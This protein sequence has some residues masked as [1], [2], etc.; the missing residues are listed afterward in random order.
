MTME[1]ST[2][3]RPSGRVPLTFDEIKTMS[4]HSTFADIPR[5]V[6]VNEVQIVPLPLVIVVGLVMECVFPIQSIAEHT[7]NTKMSQ[8]ERCETNTKIA[9]SDWIQNKIRRTPK[10]TKYENLKIQNPKNQ[11]IP[12]FVDP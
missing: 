4:I 10:S 2:L 9:I 11:Q 3:V 8:N 5:I 7:V 12:N 1:K 6:A